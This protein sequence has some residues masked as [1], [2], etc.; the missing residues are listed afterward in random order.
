MHLQKSR[1]EEE[2][3][4]RARVFQKAA[5]LR[6]GRSMGNSE[7]GRWLDQATRTRERGVWQ[8]MSL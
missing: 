3:S 5:L 7:N 8:V 1:L 2:M 6:A 4:G